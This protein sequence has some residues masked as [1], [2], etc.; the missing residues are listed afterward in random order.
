MAQLRRP[1]TMAEVGNLIAVSS[2]KGGVGKST[3]AAALALALAARGRA[4]GLL[5][6]DVHGP[7]LPT[8]FGLGQVPVENEGQNL[9]PYQHAGISLFSFGLLAG[10]NPAVLRGPMLAGVVRQLLCNVAWGKLD[11]LVLDLPPGT[12]DVHLTVSQIVGLDGAVIVS[13][14]HALAR[15]DV[16]N[17][18]LMFSQVAVPVLGLIENMAWFECGSCGAKHEVFGGSA[19][20]Q[21]QERFGLRCLARLPLLS[22]AACAPAEL[23]ARGELKVMAEAVLEALAETRDHTLL[24]EAVL[25]PARLE[26]HWPDSTLGVIEFKALRRHCRCAECEDARRRGVYDETA[27]PAEPVAVELHWLG[28]YALSVRW[29]DGHRSGIYPLTLLREL[30]AYGKACRCRHEDGNVNATP[31]N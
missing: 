1:G 13:T 3:L 6:L 8:L 14:N 5:D 26:L 15:P 17:G 27:L 7:S 9:V 4:V 16:E 28:N 19:A 18:L 24:P 29:Q 10:G 21:V 2:C 12:G 20:K 25:G 30:A 11:D 23:A 22:G 31:R